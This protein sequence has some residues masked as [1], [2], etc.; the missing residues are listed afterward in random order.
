MRKMSETL[1]KYTIDYIIDEISEEKDNLKRLLSWFDGITYDFNKTRDDWRV[2][3][4]MFLKLKEI[5]NVYQKG[6]I[7]VNNLTKNK[8]KQFTLINREL[9]Y[10][11]FILDHKGMDLAIEEAKRILKMIK[12]T[13]SERSYY[14]LKKRLNEDLDIKI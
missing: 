7:F 12:K 5:R 1:L 9:S 13:N 2:Y 11:Q 14:R 3:R 10:I 6:R 4:K 8:R